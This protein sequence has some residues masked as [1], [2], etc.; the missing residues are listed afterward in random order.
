MLANIGHNPIAPSN[1]LSSLRQQN[2]SSRYTSREDRL[3]K[4][5]Q[6]NPTSLKHTASLKLPPYHN[7]VSNNSVEYT[8]EQVRLVI[9]QIIIY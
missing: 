4:P 5:T 7:R 3:R 9:Y 1:V 2:N 8:K 6:T